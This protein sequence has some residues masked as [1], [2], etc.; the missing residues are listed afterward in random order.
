MHFKIRLILTMT[1]VGL[2]GLGLLIMVTTHRIPQEALWALGLGVGAIILAWVINDPEKT[3]DDYER[4][5]RQA[6]L[7]ANSQRAS[8][9]GG[10]L[11]W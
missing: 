4:K 3:V 11:Q 5:R 9:R 7:E 2:F 10:P 1:G 8:R 6:E